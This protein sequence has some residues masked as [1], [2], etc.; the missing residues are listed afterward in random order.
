MESECYLL[1]AQREWNASDERS[2]CPSGCF[3]VSASVHRNEDESLSIPTRVSRTIWEVCTDTLGA[4]VPVTR[5]Q[6]DRGRF[7]GFMCSLVPLLF[8]SGDTR[9]PTQAG[10]AHRQELRHGSPR[11]VAQG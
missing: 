2:P 10:S 4:S 8:M 9:G 11:M 5:V 3:L 1:K 7:G 6:L